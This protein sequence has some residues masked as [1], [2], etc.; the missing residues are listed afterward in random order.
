MGRE[1]G[2]V[3]EARTP[4]YDR[5]LSSWLRLLL[6]ICVIV[7]ATVLAAVGAEAKASNR[8]VGPAAVASAPGNPSKSRDSAGDCS[9]G[10][11]R[12]GDQTG[13][14]D[15]PGRTVAVQVPESSSLFLVGCGLLL[16]AAFLRHRFI[17]IKSPESARR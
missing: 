6:V 12:L 11:S 8:N 3:G 15:K 5:L 13:C 4:S 14:G 10:G 2:I 7:Q 17:R 16:M 1:Q 9:K